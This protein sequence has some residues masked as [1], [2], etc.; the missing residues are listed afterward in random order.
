MALKSGELNTQ[1]EL[2]MRV[3][4]VAPTALSEISAAW[5]IKNSQR[6]IGIDAVAAVQIGEQS[7]HIF[8]LEHDQR[9]ALNKKRFFERLD[10]IPVRMSPN[11]IM[12]LPWSTAWTGRNISSFIN[13]L[14]PDIVNIH[15]LTNGSINLAN[16][17]EIKCPVVL[18]LH[19]VWAVTGGC[20]CNLECDGWRRQC[21]DC[22]QLGRS[23]LGFEFAPFLRMHKVRAYARVPSLTIV[24]P[25]RWLARM[26]SES[27]CFAGRNIYVIP[28]CVN[29]QIFH[30]DNKN[31]KQIRLGL[32]PGKLVVGFG[33]V[34]AT[35]VTYKG[36]DLLIKVLEILRQ[37]TLLD[38]HL[39]VFGADD[40]G[41]ALPYEAS[42]L[43]SINR[44][45]D[46]AGIYQACDIF[47]S[48]SRQDNFPSTVLEA[49][50]CGKPV[51]AFDVGGVSDIINHR[52]SG[53]LAKPFDVIDF[54]SGIQWLLA[55]AERL[56]SA[57]QAASNFTSQY[58]SQAAVAQKYL[59]LYESLI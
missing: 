39:V 33:A 48:P 26:S 36:Y 42:F 59:N 8:T 44:E 28:N 43:G 34:N 16:L 2:M 41:H 50:S 45:E 19:D 49:A 52:V 24:C 31:S 9:I 30:P 7:E 55:S 17:C 5:R 53:Y 57:G 25:S 40:S 27:E 4:H 38:I 56:S 14:A 37:Q 21:R 22:P 20:H 58:C 32:P 10:S 35:S 3:V 54:A 29:H 13:S 23:I 46:L 51:V 6:E 18:T 1:I 47:V 15:W 12:D 11:R